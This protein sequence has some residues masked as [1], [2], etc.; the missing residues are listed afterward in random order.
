MNKKRIIFFLLIVAI[1]VFSV[2][3]WIHFQ[4][5][6]KRESL[7]SLKDDSAQ[8]QDEANGGGTEDLVVLG[9]VWHEGEATELI[10]L[11]EGR[12]KN[13]GVDF[14]CIY[15]WSEIKLCNVLDDGTITAYIGDADFKRDGSNG[16]VMV[17]IPRFYYQRN[18]DGDKQEFWIANQETACFKIHPCFLRNGVEIPYVLIGAYQAGIE[19]G[20][21]MTKL[22]SITGTKPIKGELRPTIRKWAENCGPGWQMTDIAARSA[23]N[24]LY[25]VEYAD[26]DSQKV[27]GSGVVNVVDSVAT[28]GC[29]SLNGVS[30]MAPG[31]N[32]EVSV[33]YR[34]LENLWGN[35]AEYLD[36]V[37]VK[38][39]EKEIYVATEGRY[40]DDFFKENYQ[41]TGLILP[42]PETNSVGSQVNFAYNEAYDWVF[43]P[44][45]INKQLNREENTYI[46]DGAGF[47]TGGSEIGG[48]YVRVGGALYSFNTG[49]LFDF[50]VDSPSSRGSSLTTGRL[51][52]LPTGSIEGTVKAKDGR[53][54]AGIKVQVSDLEGIIEETVTGKDG[55]YFIPNIIP[56]IHRVLYYLDEEIFL[57]EL[58]DIKVKAETVKT[59]NPVFPVPLVDFIC[60]AQTEESVQLEWPLAVG[61]ENWKILQSVDGGRTWVTTAASSKWGATTMMATVS[62]LMP[63]TT[64]QF[65]LEVA[66]GNHIECSNI[67]EVTTKVPTNNQVYGVS[68]SRSDN[69]WWGRI[70]S[71]M[72]KM[73]RLGDSI[74]KNPGEDFVQCYPWQGIKLCNVSDEG[75]ITAFGGD[76]NFRRDGSQGQVMVQLPKFYYKYVYSYEKHELWVAQNP[77]PG[78]KIHPAFVRE[79]LVKDY[80]LVGAY[81]AGEEGNEVKKL[82]SY[83]GVLPVV[84]QTMNTFRERAQVRGD[85]W[86]LVD[87]FTRSA[88]SL[89]Y[90]VEMA[91][92]DNQDMG[93]E[94][95][96]EIAV[97]GGCDYL[98]GQSGTAFDANNGVSVSYRGWENLWGYLSEVIEGLIF[99]KGLFY[100]ANSDFIE[101]GSMGS[102]RL[103][104]LGLLNY[105]VPADFI[106]VSEADWRLMLDRGLLIPHW[107]IPVFGRGFYYDVSDLLDFYDLQ[108]KGMEWIGT[109]LQYIP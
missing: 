20:E 3:G 16:Q 24:F 22:V 69:I 98:N 58:F 109:R 45:K 43:S 57:G 44:G 56:G 8:M 4:Q 63:A 28:G 17:K 14:D 26:L 97:T 33:S 79:G 94:V 89:L 55:Y 49:G 106:F 11:G 18:C 46:T 90:F 85:G 71:N 39:A 103:V 66:D 77:L 40:R 91:D 53:V 5:V 65:K 64:Y 104:G 37:N 2:F 92:W 47:F 88:I 67:V 50:S 10:R 31:I 7:V 41:S 29:D 54:L 9:V 81:L 101:P 78:F 75:E 12:G 51:L 48:G 96:D 76:E 19:K 6:A 83:S 35:Y 74:G 108:N 1:I 62:N 87:A 61:D 27:I 102:Q 105:G 30:G 82:V 21:E 86:G 107:S 60:V 34:G 25:L 95:V 38:L 68:W 93:S 13:P 59:L 73:R 42:F 23:L 80:L 15:P 36:G 84:N 100:S 72:A 70:E 52:Y 99:D 32:G